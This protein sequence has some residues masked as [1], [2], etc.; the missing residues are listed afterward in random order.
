MVCLEFLYFRLGPTGCFCSNF[1]VRCVFCNGILRQWDCGDVVEQEHRSSFPDCPFILGEDVGNI[2][3][4]PFTNGHSRTNITATNPSPVRGSSNQFMQHIGYDIDPTEERCGANPGFTQPAGNGHHVNDAVAGT[5]NSMG[6]EI[7]PRRIY[8]TSPRNPQMS[9][10]PNRLATFKTWPA[11]I[12]QRP[13]EL[14][15]AGLYYIG[16]WF[17]QWRYFGV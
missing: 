15:R 1:Q 12:R 2:P 11:Q 10:E 13:E 6:G 9:V 17:H 3:L 16:E 5:N 7:S 14:A 8:S 4:Q